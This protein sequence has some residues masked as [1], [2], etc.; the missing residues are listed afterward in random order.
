MINTPDTPLC[1][2]RE[3][4][5]EKKYRTFVGSYESETR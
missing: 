1:Y 2:S 4:M 3:G 5:M